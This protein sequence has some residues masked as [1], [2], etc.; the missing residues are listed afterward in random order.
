MRTRTQINATQ[1]IVACKCDVS[2]MM[3][4]RP[5]EPKDR[6]NFCRV[7]CGIKKNA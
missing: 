1:V 5:L 6:I 7:K 4:V 2:S 3:M